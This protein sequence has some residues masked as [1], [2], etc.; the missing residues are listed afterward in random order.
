MTQSHHPY[1]LIDLTDT[2][3]ALIGACVTDTIL[4]LQ[5]LRVQ[6]Y[7]PLSRNWPRGI[8]S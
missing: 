2:T 6:G 3:R 7:Y 4:P 1:I 5:S 8:S